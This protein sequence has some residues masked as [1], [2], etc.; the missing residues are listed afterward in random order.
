M[1]NGRLTSSSFGLKVR[2]L[3]VMPAD[4]SA[5]LTSSPKASE[6]RNDAVLVFSSYRK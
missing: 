2:A 3:V 6:T 4:I 1:E 5:S